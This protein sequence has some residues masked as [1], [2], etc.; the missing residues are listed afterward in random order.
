M[1]ELLLRAIRERRLLTFTYGDMVRVAE[2]HRYGEAVNGHRLLS[3]WLR[4][5]H[6]RSAPEGGWRSFLV[7]DIA[8]LQLLD[9]TF[10]GPREG[11]NPGDRSLVT[12]FAELAAAPADVDADEDDDEISDGIDHHRVAD[13]P[14]AKHIDSH[15]PHRD[16][17]GA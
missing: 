2:A 11:Y 12:V 7:D 16:E 3:A 8:E 14:G 13:P 6:S 1:H 5:G 4:P 10:A 15:P 17:I 9:E